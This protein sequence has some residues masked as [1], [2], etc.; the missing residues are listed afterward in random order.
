[1]NRFLVFPLLAVQVAGHCPPTGPVLPPPTIPTDFKSAGLSSSLDLLAKG[2]DR[3]NSTTTS[4]SFSVTSPD[5]TFFEFHHTAPSKNASGVKQVDKDTVYRVASNTKMYMTLAVLLAFSNNLDDP[6]GK[7]IPE[8]AAS[9]DYE[10][11]TPRLLAAHLAG[12]PRNGTFRRPSPLHPSHPSRLRL[13]SL[14][15]R[16]PGAREP[17][18]PHPAKLR[19]APL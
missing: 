15:N 19:G 17:R 2:T 3:F 9:K 18:L 8:L 14:R 7:Y 16:R 11:V 4:F 10:D 5:S 12:V 6:I 13:R 1:M